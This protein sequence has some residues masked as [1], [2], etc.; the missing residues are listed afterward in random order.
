MHA[1]LARF[2]LPVLAAILF[3]ACSKDHE[4]S[5]SVAQSRERGVLI[6]AYSVPATADLGDC[7]LREVW[8]ETARSGEQEII[9]RLD[10]P[11]HGGAMRVR[12][13]GLDEMQYRGI[14]SERN[15][16]PYERWAAP[17]PLPDK[18]RL[19]R[20]GKAVEIERKTK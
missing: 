6:A 1:S 19:E 4:S 17:S 15:G 9:V 18:L 12:I 13:A 5:S 2:T 14:W 3:S 11:H 7:R 8:A 10:A 16:P 20:N